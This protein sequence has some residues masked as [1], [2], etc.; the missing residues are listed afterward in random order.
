MRDPTIELVSQELDFIVSN[1]CDNPN[2]VGASLGVI[3]DQHLVWSCGYGFAN[4]DTESR[5]DENTIFRIASVTKTFTATALFQL[6]DAGMINLDDPL[7]N[8]IDEFSAATARQGTIE[9]VTIRRL[10]CHH[11]GL[12]CQPTTHDPYW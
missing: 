10:L 12:I 11:S 9:D 6:R 3:R 1:L 5:P 2:V 8:Y 7:T 4:K